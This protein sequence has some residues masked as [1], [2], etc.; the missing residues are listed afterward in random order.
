MD[1]VSLKPRLYM[2]DN[3]KFLLITL[4]VLGHTLTSEVI[5]NVYLR[6]VFLF[7]YSFH[8]PLFL[9]I[10]GL[11]QKKESDSINRKK[12]VTYIVLGLIIKMFVMFADGMLFSGEPKFSLLNGDGLFWYLFVLAYYHVICY[13]FRK[14]DAR[15]ILIISTLLSLFIGYDNSI[16]DFLCLSRA[17]VFFP[18]YYIGFCLKPNQV[19]EYCSKKVVRISSVVLILTWLLLNIFCIDD[20]YSLRGLF[21]GRNSY[22]DVSESFGMLHRCLT[23]LISLIVSISFISV[24]TYFNRC[25]P[26]ISQV[27][28]KTLQ[29]Y[30]WHSILL[31]VLRYF[32]TFENLETILPNSCW[33][34]FIVISL[35]IVVILSEDIFNKPIQWV[36]NSIKV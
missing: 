18:F 1:N 19:L 3:L 10:S 9:F 33:I 28:E 8:M 29:V 23:S 34:V 35:I 22:D 30:F 12:V 27:G 20:L 21:T 7:I 11:F 6:S 26:M 4:V 14:V 16:G 5:D 36:T 15:L 17:I 25:I 2:F 13:C 32:D 24:S 31:K